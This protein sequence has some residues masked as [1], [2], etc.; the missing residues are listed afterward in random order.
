MNDIIISDGAYV[1]NDSGNFIMHVQILL[2]IIIIIRVREFL[3]YLLNLALLCQFSRAHHK[4]VVNMSWMDWCWKMWKDRKV[5]LS[6]LG[7]NSQS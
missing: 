7:L 3:L 2:V 6:V 1:I 5:F 4:E